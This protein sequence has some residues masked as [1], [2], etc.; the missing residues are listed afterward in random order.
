MQPQW[1]LA[2]VTIFEL[3]RIMLVGVAYG[4]GGGRVQ[5]D[6]KEAI[7][8]QGVSSDEALAALANSITLFKALVHADK[9]KREVI[10]TP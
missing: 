7:A 8:Q 6:C 1:P 10:S 5:E 4:P 2:Q 3:K 9:G